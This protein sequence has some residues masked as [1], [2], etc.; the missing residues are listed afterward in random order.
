MLKKI[1]LNF[2]S[3][4]I[5][6]WKVMYSLHNT[7]Q[8]ILWIIFY[9]NKNKSF[10]CFFTIMVSNKKNVPVYKIKQTTFSIYLFI[11]KIENFKIQ[12]KLIISHCKNYI[13]IL[14]DIL[15]NKQIKKYLYIK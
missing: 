11:F 4:T 13:K 6:D 8:E 12:L 14:R 9:G 7:I 5:L 15:T 3:I 10:C 1:D 2:C